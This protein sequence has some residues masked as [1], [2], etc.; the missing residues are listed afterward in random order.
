MVEDI[1]TLIGG[2]FRLSSD[3]REVIT[4]LAMGLETACAQADSIARRLDGTHVMVERELMVPLSRVIVAGLE[5]L[6]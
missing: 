6:K 5:A 4:D 1:N 2:K 3:E